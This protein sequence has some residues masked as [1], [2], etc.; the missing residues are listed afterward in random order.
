MELPAA[1]VARL[2]TL[3]EGR[4]VCVTGGAGFIGGHLVDALLTLGA[5]IRVI[6]DLSNSTLGHL[7]EL[8]ELEP[9]RV[10]FVYGSILDDRALNEAL[11]GCDT[12]FHL[13]AMGSVPRSIREPERSYL[14]NATGT[15]RTLEA[16]RRAGAARVVYAASSSAYGDDPAL[17]KSEKQSPRP[18]SPYAASKLAGE[19]LVLAWARTYGLGGVSL[20]Y[21]NVFGPRQQADSAYAAVIP[22]FLK[23]VLAG[24]PPIIYGDGSQTRDFTFV[25]NA[26]LAT[27]MGGSGERTFRGEVVNVGS[28]RPVSVLELSQRLARDCP[29]AGELKP[30]FEPSRVGDVPHSVADLTLARQLLGYE[31]V[32]SLD[33]GLSETCQWFRTVFAGA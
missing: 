33:K 7:G 22:A 5:R 3:Y 4:T 10:R 30:V 15:L 17:P 31:P 27:L 14:V 20:R 28:G 26:V 12:V 8:V 9:D 23:R 13:A 24:L 21:F 19:H 1:H 29:H 16:A 25:G 11:E 6:D 18:I 32:T 2:R